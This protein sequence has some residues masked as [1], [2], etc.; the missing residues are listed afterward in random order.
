[1]ERRYTIG[2]I[3]ALPVEYSAARSVLDEEYGDASLKAGDD[4]LYLL[5][6]VGKHNVVLTCLPA[7]RTGTN[8]ASS[9]AQDLI[10]KFSS[11]TSILMVGVGGGVPKPGSD[12]R[13]GDV[14]VGTSIVQYDFG[15]VTPNGFERTRTYP[16]LP[17]KILLGAISRL[18]ARMIENRTHGEEQPAR[19]YLLPE[20]PSVSPESDLLFEASYDH[21][22]SQPQSTCGI[23]DHKKLISREPRVPQGPRV[24]FGAIASGNSVIRSGSERDKMDKELHGVLCFEME[25]AGVMEAGPCLSI[26][27]ICDYADSHKNKSL[28]NVA[29]KAA[30]AT[31]KYILMELPHSDPAVRAL[32][33]PAR[34]RILMPDSLTD[35]SYRCKFGLRSPICPWMTFLRTFLISSSKRTSTLLGRCTRF[36]MTSAYLGSL[37]TWT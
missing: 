35:S 3:S 17:P 1:M 2:W 30:A 32:S 21:E 28:Q 24:H 25:A 36:P 19:G 14:V 26:R 18:Q 11:V 4:K 27:G 37:K 12:I 31:A 10:S 5:G 15:K 33:C 16:G 7:G 20:F 13:L 23:C 29:A 6:R 22:A 8:S 34:T 9:A